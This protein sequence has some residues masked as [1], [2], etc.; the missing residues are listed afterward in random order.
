MLAAAAEAAAEAAGAATEAGTAAA[1]PKAEAGA[2]AAA[3]ANRGTTAATAMATCA[4]P[5]IYT[6]VCAAK[7][8][9][10]AAGSGSGSSGAA[11]SADATAAVRRTTYDNACAAE[12]EGAGV[13]HVGRCDP[14]GG[15]GEGAGGRLL[16]NIADRTRTALQRTL[17]A[18]GIGSA[19]AHTSSSTTSTPTSTTTT[20][21]GGS[22][23]PPQQTCPAASNHDAP[24]TT[25]ASAC[26]AGDRSPGPGPGPGPAG[27]AGGL[28]GG[29]GPGLG[30]GPAGPGGR[31]AARRGVRH[32]LLPLWESNLRWLVLVLVAVDPAFADVRPMGPHFKFVGPITPGARGEGW[33]GVQR[34]GGRNAARRGAVFACACVRCMRVRMAHEASGRHTQLQ[35][36]TGACFALLLD[37]LATYSG[38]SQLDTAHCPGSCSRPCSRPC[39]GPGPCPSEPPLPLPADVQR[40]VAPPPADTDG[41]SDGGATQPPHQPTPPHRSGVRVVYV[42]PGSTFSFG[43]PGQAHLLKVGWVGLGWVGW[44]RW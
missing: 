19:L 26:T 4:C 44:G 43:D 31:L 21:S 42:S 41:E 24:A 15:G 38:G 18:I 6:P 7:P 17:G 37:S 22:S 39:P 25:I 23:Q 33:R 9:A 13:L 1:V 8:A 2:A 16:R 20:I 36:R 40:F 10:A 29:P 34:G 28:A 14:G 5:A 11:G 30:P 3:N 32:R 27:L 12:C 35:A